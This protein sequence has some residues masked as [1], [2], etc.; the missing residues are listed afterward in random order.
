MYRSVDVNY[1]F[2][3]DEEEALAIVK[4]ALVKIPGAIVHL[5]NHQKSVELVS[6]SHVSSTKEKLL[7]I[8]VDTP[9]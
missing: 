7:I 6:A 3:D 1:L 9:S 2:K 8:L 5:I 4:E